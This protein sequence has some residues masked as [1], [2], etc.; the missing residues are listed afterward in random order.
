MELKEFFSPLIEGPLDGTFKSPAEAPVPGAEPLPGAAPEMTQDIRPVS[1]G[2]FTF[3][4]EAAQ[5]FCDRHNDEEMGQ[6]TIDPSA[7]QM[8]AAA[9][10]NLAFQTYSGLSDPEDRNKY[11]SDIVKVSADFQDALHGFVADIE[12]LKK[13]AN[14]Y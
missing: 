4:Q 7:V 6:M 5:R 13:H 14:P 2:S 9:L 3:F 11:E 1:E 10:D 8:F 12:K